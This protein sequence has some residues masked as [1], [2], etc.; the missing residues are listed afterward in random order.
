[1]AATDNPA[2]YTFVRKDHVTIEVGD[3]SS[4]EQTEL[5]ALGCVVGDFTVEDSYASTDAEP[6]DNWCR[7]I[8]DEGGEA[9]IAQV[10]LGDRTIEFSPTIEMDLSDEGYATEYDAYST[11]TPRQF[12][13][14]FTNDNGDEQI[15]VVNGVY[16]QWNRTARDGEGGAGTARVDISFHANEIITDEVEP[17]GN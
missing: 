17:S 15:L 16:T 14:T 2:G 5:H 13:I 11:R 8:A 9:G 6:F 4:S 12:A 1:M 3:S 7:H 10:S